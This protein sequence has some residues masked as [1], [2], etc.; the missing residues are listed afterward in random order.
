MTQIFVATT[1]ILDNIADTFRDKITVRKKGQS[2]LGGQKVIA[3]QAWDKFSEGYNNIPVVRIYWREETYSQ[4]SQTDRRTLG[5]ANDPMRQTTMAVFFDIVTTRRSSIA[6]DFAMA[7]EIKDE[8]GEI[9]HAQNQKPY[10]NDPYIKAWRMR[11]SALAI[12]E[13]YGGDDVDYVGIRNEVEFT[14]F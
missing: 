6:P 9:M 7:L 2:I 10:F 3:V 12:F 8:I 4:D 1:D 11:R 13:S 14:I 5:G